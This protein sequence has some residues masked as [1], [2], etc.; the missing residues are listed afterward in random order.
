V[1]E[2]TIRIDTEQRDLLYRYLI[3]YAEALDTFDDPERAWVARAVLEALGAEP[4]GDQ[5]LYELPRSPEIRAFLIEV[6]DMEWDNVDGGE[7][8][9]PERSADA[10]ATASRLLLDFPPPA[11]A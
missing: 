5:A 1:L 8:V 9:D 2:P 7:S 3:Q 4:D 6:R 10:L 11:T